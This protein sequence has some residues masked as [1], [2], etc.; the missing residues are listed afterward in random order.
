MFFL[1]KNS[2]GERALKKDRAKMAPAEEWK[3]SE[4]DA[5]EI[6][7]ETVQRVP[8]ETAQDKDLELNVMEA[9][10]TESVGSAAEVFRY[11][12]EIAAIPHG[13]FNTKALSDALVAF[14]RDRDLICRQDD[15]NNVV[16]TAP[17]APG[18]EDAEPIALQGHIDMVCEA[19]P[20]RKIDMAAEAITVIE[21]GDWLRADGTTLGG[22]DGIAV[23]MMLA[24]LSD[25]AIPHPLLECIFTSEEEVGLLGASA[26]DLTGLKSRRML[27][28][29]SEEEG[30]FTAGCAGGAEEVCALAL[31]R[32][33]KEGTYLTVTV[34]GLRGG[35]SGD[36]INRG[37]GNAD[38]L[39]ARFLYNLYKKEKFCVATLHGG[40]RDNAIPRTASA[41]ILPV[42]GMTS[43]PGSKGKKNSGA[44][45]RAAGS[46][47]KQWQTSLEKKMRKIAAQITAEYASTD[48]DI[49]FSW[50]WNGESEQKYVFGKKET[51]RLLQF[52]LALPNGVLEYTPG[53]GDL[54]QTSLNMGILKTTAD[55]VFATFL[56][57]SS[58]NSQ[59]KMLM[60]KLVC[61]TEGFGGTVTTKSEYPAWE[62]QEESPF[63]EE[64]CRIYEETTGVKPSVAVIHGGLEC[65]ILA[66]K[67]AGLDCVSCGP[68]MEGVHTSEERLSISSTERI[69]SFVKALLA[70]K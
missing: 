18:Y 27:N 7:E 45:E 28:L 59:K 33:E 25:P 61:V 43:G 63:R 69:W 41:Q 30:V 62:F 31:R 6:P 50:S 70:A 40:G 54:P 48:P 13:S 56:V 4:E 14:A 22:D 8:E 60:D 49:Q 16:I 39:L 15:S 58:I 66:S 47:E 67:V 68:N 19:D 12:R 11:F 21:D 51:L 64:V 9:Q 52:V 10:E 32:K 23:A 2:R 57:R 20:G 17:A 38:I 42:S 36:E 5:E 1:R 35:H 29:D 46:S 44:G 26:L 3:S 53:F 37:R 34:S 24:I 65:G 55:G